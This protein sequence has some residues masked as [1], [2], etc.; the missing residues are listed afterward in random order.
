[1]FKTIILLK[2]PVNAKRG[3][4]FRSRNVS[5]SRIE[6]RDLRTGILRRPDPKLAS[7]L[8]GNILIHHR[9][10]PKFNTTLKRGKRVKINIAGQIFRTFEDTINR[11]PDT[12]LGNPER[13]KEYYDP[14]N[15]EYFFDRHRESFPAILYFYQSDGIMGK[16]RLK[17]AHG[18]KWVRLRLESLY[19]YISSRD[20]IQIIFRKTEMDSFGYFHRRNNLFWIDTLFRRCRSRE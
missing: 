11:M 5:I 16:L 20:Q 3:P 2:Q 14:E 9:L 17:Y 6:F 10:Q 18:V 4:A 1:M 13:R 19:L 7:F 8:P 12:V 15:N